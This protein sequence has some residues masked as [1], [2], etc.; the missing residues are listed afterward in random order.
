MVLTASFTPDQKT[1]SPSYMTF[2]AADAVDAVSDACLQCHGPSF[3]DLAARTA[4]YIDPW[5]QNVNPHIYVDVNKGKPHDSTIVTSCTQCHA[6][7]ALPQPVEPVMQ[8]NL[9]YCYSCHHTEEF[10]SCSTCHN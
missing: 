3:Q 8:A 10:I 9:Q 4:D 1:S 7:H 5:G 6:S 2:N